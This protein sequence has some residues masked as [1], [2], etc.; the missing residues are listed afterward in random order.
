[1][2]E[3]QEFMTKTYADDGHS[4]FVKVTH[5]PSGTKVIESYGPS[6]DSDT[7]DA[8]KELA[9]QKLNDSIEGKVETPSEYDPLL[10]QAMSLPDFIKG[11]EG[12]GG[13]H[14]KA[15]TA[16]D[17]ADAAEELVDDPFDYQ[18]PDPSKFTG[19]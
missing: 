13:Q 4:G 6:E 19:D 11:S 17:E 7:E 10:A 14:V 15:V 3:D 12:S 18:A 16:S 2:A 1:M 5:T 9:L 8:A